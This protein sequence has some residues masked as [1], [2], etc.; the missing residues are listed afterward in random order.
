MK[1]NF[2]LQEIRD[3]S[4]SMSSFGQRRPT[5]K[6]RRRG[7]WS[8]LPPLLNNFLGETVICLNLCMCQGNPWISVEGQHKPAACV[9]SS[10]LPSKVTICLGRFPLVSKHSPATI[11]MTETKRKPRM[12]WSQCFNKNC[13]LEA[14]ISGAAKREKSEREI[15]WDERRIRLI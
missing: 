5:E 13:K 4:Y 11:F 7:D 15:R 3:N 10:A 2:S 1:L 8:G 6:M 9:P 14:N 12:F